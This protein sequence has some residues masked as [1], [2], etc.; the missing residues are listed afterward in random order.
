MQ[1]LIL[2]IV[3]LGALFV[4][5]LLLGNTFFK[6]KNIHVKRMEDFREIHSSNDSIDILFMGNSHAYNTF[7]P[8][9]FDRK[10]KT[11]SFVMA[12]GAQKL[13][14]SLYLFEKEVLSRKKLP[15]LLVLE[16]NH[17]NLEG[18]KNDNQKLGQYQVYDNSSLDWQSIG[19]LGSIFGR[20]N[21]V[22]SAFPV[23]RNHSNWTEVNPFNSSYTFT[24]VNSYYKN[25]FVGFQRELKPNNLD[26]PLRSEISN[27]GKI[28]L[29]VPKIAP[30]EIPLSTAAK[31]DLSEFIR[32]CKQNNIK[33]LVVTAP[34][35]QILNGNTS[36]LANFL[37]QEEVTYLNITDSLSSLNLR[38]NDFANKGHLNFKGAKKVSNWLATQIENSFELAGREGTD[39]YEQYINRY[40]QTVLNSGSLAACDYYNEANHQ[41]DP[42]R[43][44]NSIGILKESND[45]IAVFFDISYQA[46]QR[47]NYRVRFTYNKKD[48]FYLSERAK[49]MGS[50]EENFEIQGIAKRQG[51]R[52]LLLQRNYVPLKSISKIELIQKGK[53]PV[54]SVNGPFE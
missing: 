15:E 42:N 4:A 41:I 3:V 36:E 1:R 44:L 34:Y 53:G 22:S 31:R 12:S 45:H 30:Y 37:E 19:N 27:D 9:I 43:K 21:I 20:K 5:A 26:G 51:D 38:L 54:F 23:V 2:K 39:S 24:N 10:F 11:K 46:F 47:D 7:F 52:I 13:E 14:S 32:L 29:I 40:S 48:R 16:V 8:L 28:E 33:L 49:K 18:Y 35:F 25:G 17:M 50:F 6:D